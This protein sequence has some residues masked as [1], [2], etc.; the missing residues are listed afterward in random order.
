MTP[1]PAFQAAYEGSIPF[2]R[3]NKK[4]NELY[5]K[6]FRNTVKINVFATKYRP[7]VTRRNPPF[8]EMARTG[9]WRV[10]GEFDIPKR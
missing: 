4:I 9:L 2:T 7:S 5:R 8:S 6:N 1:S 3:S 10:C